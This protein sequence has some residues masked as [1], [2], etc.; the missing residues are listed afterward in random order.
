MSLSPT[1]WRYFPNGDT[2]QTDGYIIEDAE[3]NQVGLVSKEEDAKRIVTSV[4]FV[5][6]NNP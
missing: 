1:P 3:D 4:N 5:A 2:P 6:E